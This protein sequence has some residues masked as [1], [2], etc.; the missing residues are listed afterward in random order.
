MTNTYFVDQR[1]VVNNC[2]SCDVLWPPQVLVELIVNTLKSR[3]HDLGI[4]NI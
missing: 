4:F 3:S 1:A 2:I